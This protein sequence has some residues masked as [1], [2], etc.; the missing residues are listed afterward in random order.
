[1]LGKPVRPLDGSSDREERATSTDRW[2]SRGLAVG[3]IS[4][5]VVGALAVVG[6]AV[7]WRPGRKR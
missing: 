3:G 5:L 1:V 2:L 6:V 7:L 4:L